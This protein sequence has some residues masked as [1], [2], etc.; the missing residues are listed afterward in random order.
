MKA[1][2]IRGRIRS[3][4]LT[5]AI[6]AAI[7]GQPGVVAKVPRRQPERGRVLIGAV[8][9]A[10]KNPGGAETVRAM[11]TRDSRRRLWWSRLH[12]AQTFKLSPPRGSGPTCV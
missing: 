6:D 1:R 2:G 8:M 11:I 5:A 7:A 10:T 4:A 3:G 9:K 12:T